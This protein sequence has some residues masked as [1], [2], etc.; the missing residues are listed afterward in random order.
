MTCG[1][2][3]RQKKGPTISNFSTAYPSLRRVLPSSSTTTELIGYIV[4]LK[5]V[6]MSS[7]RSECNA[8]G[9]ALYGILQPGTHEGRCLT[10]LVGVVKHTGISGSNDVELVSISVIC[11]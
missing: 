11:V 5:G 4:L 1:R 3:Y 7:S 2:G 10:S 8:R 9:V 6:R